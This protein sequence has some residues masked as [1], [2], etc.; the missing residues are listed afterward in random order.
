MNFDRRH[1]QVLAAFIVCEI[2]VF[3]ITGYNFFS[4]SNFFECIRLAVELG[5]IAL[6][7]TPVIVTGGIDLSVG[8][9]MGLCAVTFG[10]LIKDAHAP[11][12]LAIALV[13]LVS[14]VGGALNGLLVSLLGVSPLI[15]T[16]A[17]YSLFRGIAEVVTGGARNYSDFPADFL[18]LGQGYVAG[19]VPAQT[20]LILLAG[21]GFW[22][23]LHRTVIGRG[24]YAIGHS[25][26]AARYAAIPVSRWLALV[27]VLSGF[28]AGV[29]GLVYVAHLGQ[30]KSDAG[31]QYELIAI[32]AVV[33]GGTSI[34][35]GS[36][37]IRGTLLGLSAI[38]ILQNGLR[39]SAWPTELAGISTGVLLL[40]TVAF[41]KLAT[42]IEQSPTKRESRWF[43]RPKWALIWSTLAVLIVLIPVGKALFGRSEQSAGKRLTVGVMPKAKG[44]PYFISCRAGAEQAAR[45]LNVNL[46]WDGP[47]G[48]DAA[49]QNEIVEGWITR[50][51]DAISVAVENAP[52]ISTVLRKARAH[53]IKTVTWDA[54]A[55]P[56]SRDYFLNQATPQAIGY[57][58]ID[59]SAR[60]MKGQG[61]FAVITGALSAAN[62]NLW[63]SYMKQ[64]VAE[65]HPGLKMVTIRPSDDDRDKAFSEAQTLLKVYPNLKV[66]VAISAPAVP[67]AAEAVKQSGRTDV[68]VIGLSLPSLCKPYVHDGVIEAVVLWNT[69]NLGYLAVAAPAA[70]VRG[71][72]RLGQTS[73][74][75]PHLGTLKIEGSDIILGAP[76]FFRRGNIDRFHF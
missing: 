7:M 49:K 16:L 15:V 59:E 24:L 54:D 65:A 34:F 68:Q 19:V 43:N 18:F 23:L 11:L 28:S 51:V 41:Q 47:T 36:G 3:S 60:V 1:E 52:G 4:V 12:G 8:S 30:A 67:G 44:D 33:L 21:A 40:L 2:A 5:F 71:T 75:M 6:A 14:V 32:T 64:R 20:F 58:L 46:I 73:Y 69:N 31:T 57:A 61:E 39:L 42:R 9:M 56:D 22:L 53:G 27:Y 10:A 63:I 38:V 48:L 17:S 62:Q 66:I 72:L 50:H 74:R 35:G 70:L 45:D 29:A 26:E 25:A 76:V 13:L 37:S 55:E